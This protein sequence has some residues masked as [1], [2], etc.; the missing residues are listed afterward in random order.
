MASRPSRGRPLCLTGTEIRIRTVRPASW[1]SIPSNRTSAHRH[2]HIVIS[3]SIRVRKWPFPFHRL[4]VRAG[5]AVYSSVFTKPTYPLPLP[6]V[7]P[8]SS[9]HPPPVP[10]PSDIGEW[11]K[12]KTTVLC[13]PA[14]ARARASSSSSLPL[15]PL[16]HLTASIT[17]PLS[18][19]VPLRARS[20]G[21]CGI[22][23]SR[24]DRLQHLSAVLNFDIS[25]RYEA[26]RF[27]CICSLVENA[28]EVDL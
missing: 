7:H 17:Y 27:Q 14:R 20:L 24:Q 9:L 5:T 25:L 3:T 11:E 8:S 13:P 26:S 19:L 21:R 12:K 23:D 4:P 6:L 28:E 15:R 18:S 22:R 1:I 2:Q 10:P 16:L